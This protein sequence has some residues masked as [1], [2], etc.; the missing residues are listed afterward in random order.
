MRFS[1]GDRDTRTAR[2]GSA[3]FS[4]RAKTREKLSFFYIF[5]YHMSTGTDSTATCYC[6]LYVSNV[7]KN[8]HRVVI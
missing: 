8:N 4:R 2:W 6:I 5:L 1:E 3:S 7:R